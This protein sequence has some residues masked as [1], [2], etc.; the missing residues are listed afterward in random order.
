MDET[1]FADTD[2]SD[3]FSF[4]LFSLLFSLKKEKKLYRTL[5]KMRKM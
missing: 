3:F 2:F 4:I 1:T 5:L